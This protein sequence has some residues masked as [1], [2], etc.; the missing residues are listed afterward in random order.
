MINKEILED[1]IKDSPCK[2]NGL[3]DEGEGHWCFLRDLVLS[4]GMGNRN[5]EQ[6]RLM[7]DYKYMK[8]KKEGIDIGKERAFNEFVAQYG[9][10]FSQVYKEGMI[11]GEL[12]QAVF[13]F[14]KEHTDEDVKDYITNN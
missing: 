6:L 14:E 3:C 12:F 10:K 1:L 4:I 5:A 8:S 13:G 11:N 7:Y 9:E 2:K